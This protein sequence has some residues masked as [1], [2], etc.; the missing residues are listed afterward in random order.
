M[1]QLQS[2]II[3]NPRAARCGYV[4]PVAPSNIRFKLDILENPSAA[5]LYPRDI[6]SAVNISSYP[7]TTQESYVAALIAQIRANYAISDDA[8]VILT[9]GSDSAIKL[10]LDVCSHAG[11]T[12]IAPCPT[13]PHALHFIHSVECASILTPRCSCAE[14]VIR[15]L[16]GLDASTSGICYITNP[17][18]PFGYHIAGDQIRALARKLPAIVFIVDEA[19]FEYGPDDSQLRALES[20][21]I[22]LRT[23]SKIFGLAGL[24]IGYLVAH[25][26]IGDILA[27]NYNA[28]NVT[29]I[30]AAYAL[31]G[32]SHVCRPMIAQ[33]H[34]ERAFLA[35][36]LPQLCVQYREKPVFVLHRSSQLCT[37]TVSQTQEAPST[38]IYAFNLQYGN[39]Y[40]IYCHDTMSVCATFASYGIRVRDKHADIPYAIRI[41][42]QSH[43]AN[44]AALRVIQLI[45]LP[46]LLRMTQKPVGFDLDGT[47]RSNCLSPVPR[48]HMQLLTDM[49]H[50]CVITNDLTLETL[51]VL[52]ELSRVVQVITPLDYFRK[53]FSYE[54][55]AELSRTRIFIPGC[56]EHKT[57][58]A[59]AVGLSE[60]QVISNTRSIDG[61]TSS[62]IYVVIIDRFWYN[63]RQTVDLCSFIQSHGIKEIYVTDSSERCDLRNCGT[64]VGTRNLR[65]ETIIPD[66]L[67]QIRPI[68]QA[69]NAE[70]RI[71][72]KPNVS[73]DEMNEMLYL[74]GDSDCDMQQ[75]ISCDPLA[76]HIHVV[77]LSSCNSRRYNIEHDIFEV[78][79]LSA[80]AILE[81]I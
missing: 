9:C 64:L 55:S 38:P 22:V 52:E 57:F 62:H 68:A 27:A 50:P 32:L 5:S 48:V 7:G 18:L 77:S 26:A 41:C 43:E 11:A 33:Y 54:T 34:E 6:A 30:A 45:N 23:F 15:V 17:N 69:C 35:R 71:I 47:L 72:G 65:E 25:R 59:R 75:K 44:M 61:L 63:L 21:V 73:V 1:Q 42:I 80:I 16:D 70:I 29:E 2:T 76:A 56:D 37:Q 10:I 81:A 66:M 78:G 13:Y 79:A 19:Y 46:W 39:F 3:I 14:D 74:V 8:S 28:K 4:L 36:E 51:R 24:R 31:Y 12:I 60:D 40:L 67:A 20:N 58:V 49:A 53:R